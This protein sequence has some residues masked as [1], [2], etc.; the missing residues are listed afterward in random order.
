MQ[1][2]GIHN[3]SHSISPHNYRHFGHAFQEI[4]KARGIQG[5]YHGLGATILRDAPF[6]A[7]QF[8]TYESLKS[9][10]LSHTP[11]M[12]FAQELTIGALAGIAA[13]ALTTPLDTVKTYLQTQTKRKK[14][15]VVVNQQFVRA[16]GI[17]L[18][19][20]Y[21]G[22]QSAVT[23]IYGRSGWRGLFRGMGP[24]VLW[25]GCQSCVMF[26]LYETFLSLL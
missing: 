18:A 22:V 23:G 19:P 7:I 5:V 10:I 15:E 2:Q 1:L 8:M 11:Q 16:D 21:S 20:H 6:T 4:W 13:G 17:P 3:N 24:R 12:S 26:V 14:A 25:T 9:F